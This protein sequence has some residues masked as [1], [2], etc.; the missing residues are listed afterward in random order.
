ML[1]IER[2]ALRKTV[3]SLATSTS[4]RSAL[5]TLLLLDAGFVIMHLALHTGG[6][7]TPLGFASSTMW[8]LRPKAASPKSTATR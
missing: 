6:S 4:F 1:S 5:V 2:R 3:S 8:S 7:G